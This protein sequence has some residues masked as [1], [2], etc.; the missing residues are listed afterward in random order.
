MTMTVIFPTGCGRT[1]GSSQSQEAGRCRNPD[2]GQRWSSWWQRSWWQR[3]AWSAWSAWSWEWWPW[4]ASLSFLSQ[5][6]DQSQLPTVPTPN[7]WP[8]AI[9]IIIFL[10]IIIIIIIVISEKQGRVVVAWATWLP[11]SW[12]EGPPSPDAGE[13][14]NAAFPICWGDKCT[15]ASVSEASAGNGIRRIC[16]NEK[17]LSKWEQWQH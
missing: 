1:G 8:M 6:A 15:H 5:P 3:S 7:W 12:A 2:G 4:L 13:N 9:V 10:I 14:L 17:Y 11:E 16:K